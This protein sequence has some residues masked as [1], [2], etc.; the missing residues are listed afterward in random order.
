VEFTL[1]ARGRAQSPKVIESVPAGTFDA[2]ALEA[3]RS[4]HFETSALGSPPQPHRAR[5]L[6]S[7]K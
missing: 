1:D 6:V 2:A 3:V 7:F 4:S 5:L